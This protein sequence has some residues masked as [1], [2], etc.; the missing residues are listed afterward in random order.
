MK[1]IIAAIALNLLTA[2]EAAP[3]LENGSFEGVVANTSIPHGWYTITETPDTLDIIS[4][5]GV[6]GLPFVSSPAMSADGGTW[7]GL[8]R[9]DENQ[10]SESFGQWVEGFTVGEIYSLS[11]L[12]GNFGYAFYTNSNAI[13]VLLDGI[14]VGSGAA[15]DLS[16]EWIEESISFIATASSHELAFRLRDQ[17]PSYHSIDGVRLFP[18]IAVNV[19]EPKLFLLLIVAV[20]FFVFRNRRLTLG[21]PS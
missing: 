8:G 9:H 4:N 21:I 16:S 7:V 18:K 2:V 10:F 11:W 6:S 14:I 3:I 13:E 20:L 1:K 5:V 17:G 15:L 12:H 19:S